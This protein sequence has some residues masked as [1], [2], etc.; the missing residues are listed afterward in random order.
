MLAHNKHLIVVGG[1]GFPYDFS[2]AMGGGTNCQK[3]HGNARTGKSPN[4]A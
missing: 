1:Q 3:L 4:T 2:M